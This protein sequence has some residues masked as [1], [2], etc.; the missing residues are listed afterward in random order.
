M[1]RK[2]KHQNRQTQKSTN[3]DF[4]TDNGPNAWSGHHISGRFGNPSDIISAGRLCKVYPIYRQLLTSTQS[5]YLRYIR[6]F[7]KLFHRF[8]DWLL[9]C[10]MRF[11]LLL[12]KKYFRKCESRIKICQQAITFWHFESWTNMYIFQ[13]PNIIFRILQNNIV[14]LYYIEIRFDKLE[15]L[16]KD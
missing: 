2:L 12:W 5:N 11:W 3:R 8:C 1:F 16:A 10:D 14:F 15:I 4:T 6:R 9:V 13:S 7:D